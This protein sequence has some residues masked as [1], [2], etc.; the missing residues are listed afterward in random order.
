MPFEVLMLRL[1]GVER[2]PVED[3]AP[4]AGTVPEGHLARGADALELIKDMGAHR[5]HARTPADKDHFRIRV[6][7]EE[8]SVRS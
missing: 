7:C 6:T 5:G 3:F 1:Q 2:L 8:L 4:A